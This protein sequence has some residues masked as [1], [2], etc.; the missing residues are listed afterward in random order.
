MPDAT[1]D[2]NLS[3]G[4][5]NIVQQQNVFH[6]R[7]RTLY[8]TQAIHRVESSESPKTGVMPNEELDSD[9][10]WNS[11]SEYYACE[12]YDVA[13]DGGVLVPLTVVYSKKLKREGSPGLLHVHGAYGEVLD[14][15][16][17]FELKSL[18]DRGWVIAYADVR[19]VPICSSYIIHKH[20]CVLSLIN[21][22]C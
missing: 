8:G 1:V 13:S 18:L 3:N 6:E 4:K 9:A 19:Y 2:Y 15:D 11:L 17:R 12:Y 20:I 14:K 10:L 5:W 21:P 7:T 22:E 16:W